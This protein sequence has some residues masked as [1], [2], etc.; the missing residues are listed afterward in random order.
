MT[1]QAFPHLL[2]PLTIG[3]MTLRNRCVIPGHSMRLGSDLGVTPRLAEYVL[4]RARGGAAMVGLE[5]APVSRATQV[6][7][8]PL[9][10]FS[11]D[12]VSGLQTLSR[13]VHDEGSRLSV[14]LWHGGHNIPHYN[15][16]APVSASAIPSPVTGTTPRAAS[17]VEIADIVASYASAARRCADAGLDAVEIQTSSD[18]LLGSFLS[19][20][21]NLRNDHYGG[22]L[23]NRARIVVEIVAAVR[24]EV[25]QR[26]AV[27]VRTS[28]AHHIPGDPKPYD[29]PQSLATLRYLVAQGGLD[30][31]SLLEGSHWSMERIIPPMAWPRVALRNVA[32]TFRDALS[33]PI[34]FAG[35]IRR[36]E[37]AEEALAS[38]CADAIGM[39]RA[40]IADPDW[41]RKV[42]TSRRDEIR[43]CMSCNQGCLGHVA[44][45]MSGTC[46]L[47]VSAGRE[48]ERPEPSLA[49]QPLRVAV[50]GAG[51]AGLEAARVAALRGHTVDVYER[52]H[53]PGGQLR[54]AGQVEGRTDML[55]P[56]DWWHRELLR[57]GVTLH[58]G[59]DIDPAT[60][61]DADHVIWA[62]G[63]RPGRTATLRRRPWLVDGV[64]GTSGLNHARAVL[65]SGRPLVGD[66]LLIDEEGGWPA[67][68][69]A[70][71]LGQRPEISRLTV[72]TAEVRLGESDTVFTM[73][74]A[75][76]RNVLRDRR[77]VLVEGSL[78]ASVDEGCALLEDGRRLGPFDHLVL[79]TGG[80]VRET[81][82][83]A[84]IAGDCVAPRNL[85]AAVEDAYR[86]AA[87][88]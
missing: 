87:T 53:H 16:Y 3:P 33:V 52:A 22:S 62:V 65:E 60:P 4:A 78:V 20:R 19:P 59:A 47:N 13:A 28:V 39:V 41:L 84:L 56:I 75:Q 45:G 24:R 80:S 17:T 64:P 50:V 54:L 66:V 61:P 26:I 86:I 34:V 6:D 5:S 48:W 12:V 70:L 31:V 79:S 85:W 68:S 14:I 25:A 38:G 9:P 23:E 57:L 2:S 10:L 72:V 58:W 88:L 44:R 81:P 82:A 77:I 8:S 51:P 55:A 32:K 46:V 49:A 71:A 18:Y 40:W 7:L 37:E 73:E 43:P 83:D 21:L 29:E 27:G 74:A 67:L 1:E 42:A 36:A 69:F 76:V 30:Y 11:D 35:R 63:A 15:G